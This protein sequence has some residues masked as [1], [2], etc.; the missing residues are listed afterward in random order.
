MQ[1]T[2]FGYKR[3]R[4]LK[5]TSLIMALSVIAYLLH[6]PAMRESYGG[7]WLG[8]VLGIASALIAAVLQWYGIRKR[9]PASYREQGTK[10]HANQDK[11]ASRGGRS[12]QGWL[13]A[14]V[15]LGA[16]LLV[17]ATLHSGF[18]FGPDIHTLSYLLMIAVIGSGFYGVLAY[19]RFP[20]LIT[21]NM[22]EDTLAL[23]LIK[24]AELDELALAKTAQFPEHIR[25]LVTKSCTDTRTGGNVFQ[26]LSPHQEDCPTAA[27]V[28]QLPELG[29][30]LKSV[31]RE[32]LRELYSM[33]LRKQKL[34]SRVRFDI[35][36]K[37][38]LQFWLYLHA[39]LSI[40]FMTALTAHII[41]ILFY[42]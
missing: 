34:L 41:S 42:W 30:E 26:L 4:Y 25:T 32:E 33:L 8:Y 36:Y 17:L 11:L 29:K 18:Q 22:G 6:T 5:I 19:L 24:I 9:C 3:F 13:S 28:K 16:S 10:R 35:M 12:L 21:E 2:I 23:L 14:H 40:A 31:R 15:Y 27:I 1:H 20:R 38:R 7:T 39:P 37:A